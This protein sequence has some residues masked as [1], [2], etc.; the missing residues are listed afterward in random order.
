[1]FAVAG[2]S[3]HV[4]GALA[5]S[6]FKQGRKFR[7]IVRNEAKGAIWKQRGA[8]V[9]VASLGDAAALTAALRGA[10]AAFLLLPPD[11]GAP[12]LFAAQLPVAD[13]IAEAVRESGIFHLVVLSSMGAWLDEG[14]GPIVALHHL[15]KVTRKA[16]LSVTVLRGA[17][18]LDNLL[19]GLESVRKRGLLPTFL[20]PGRPLHMVASRDLGLLAG[21][22]LE[23]PEHGRRIVELSG[24]R[25]FTPEDVA[26]ELTALLGRTVRVE[27]A[28]L[29]GVVP[30]FMAG[31]VSRASAE[32]LRQMIDALNTGVIA[33]DPL[34]A[35]QRRGEW[36]PA[37]VFG[38]AM[39]L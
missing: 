8:E 5:E 15:E 6:L 32:L 16:A 23:L 25:E 24:P 21:E 11:Y 19:L 10:D 17:Y 37:E 31:G 28:P 13:A 20:T 2:V 38:R 18:F 26:R 12:D 3:G 7:V 34:R 14:T 4:G 30:A 36:G 33:P 27:A 29:D 1:V 35:Q 39:G 22:L 9:A